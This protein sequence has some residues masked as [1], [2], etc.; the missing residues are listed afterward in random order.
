MCHALSQHAPQFSIKIQPKHFSNTNTEM[1]LILK[2]EYNYFPLT[3][4]ALIN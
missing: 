2:L 4:N 3:V 1:Y